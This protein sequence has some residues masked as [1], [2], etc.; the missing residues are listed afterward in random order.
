MMIYDLTIIGDILF[1]LIAQLS[2]YESNLIKIKK[3]K[4]L[5]ENSYPTIN[6][7]FQAVVYSKSAKTQLQST[8]WFT[9]S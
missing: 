8:T 3:E 1:S 9:S 6:V 2:F 5:V 4:K 7:I